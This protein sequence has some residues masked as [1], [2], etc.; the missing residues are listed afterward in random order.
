MS[1]DLA[2]LQVRSSTLAHRFRGPAARHY[3]GE[4]SPTPNLTSFSNS[5]GPAAATLEHYRDWMGE[6]T[7]AILRS[8]PRITDRQKNSSGPVVKATRMK[9]KHRRLETMSKGDLTLRASHQQVYGI[10]LA[11]ATDFS[12]EVATS[13]VELGQVVQLTGLSERTVSRLI[14]DLISVGLIARRKCRNQR[15]ETTIW[16]TPGHTAHEVKR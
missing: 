13:F 16:R 7:Q 6:F 15:A 14:V 10:L 11:F 12:G 1:T 3:T 4:M 5:P 2:D 8:A 9:I